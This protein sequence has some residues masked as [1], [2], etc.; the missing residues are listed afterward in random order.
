MDYLG[1][2][3]NQPTGIWANIIGLFGGFINNYTLSI[4]LI[5][6][7]IKLLLSPFDFMNKKVARDNGRMQAVLGSQLMKLKKQY[8]SD[9]RML[10]QKTAE[11]Y[12]SNGFNMGTSC[13]V[14]LVYLVLTILI[15]FTLFTGLNAQVPYRVEN[16]YLELRA[17]YQTVKAADG[18]EQARVAVLEQ[19]DARNSKFLWVQNVWFADNAWTT[20]VPDFNGYLGLIGDKVVREKG[21]ETYSLS[22]IKTEQGQAAYD[23]FIADF[24]AEYDQVMTNIVKAERGGANGYMITTLLA[25]GTAF[26]AQFLMQRKNTARASREN[27][28]TTTVKTNKVMLIVLPALMGVIT[29]F[30][31]AVFGMYIIASQIMS[32]LLFPLFDVF[33]DKIDAKRQLKEEQKIMVDY[34]RK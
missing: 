34:R 3:V 13:I 22:H 15:F 21:G 18:E 30:Y 17:T 24:R 8:A 32:M 25:V 19:Y 28:A 26:L 9:P 10:N 29:L 31:N 33:L 20:S 12:R 5:T 2:F 1:L 23:A 11:L 4:I 7:I 27:G 6:V 14:M 16:Q